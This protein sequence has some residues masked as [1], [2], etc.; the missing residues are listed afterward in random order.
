MFEGCDTTAWPGNV[1][2]LS[3]FVCLLSTITK[4]ENFM[5]SNIQLRLV[6][7]PF[8]LLCT[9]SSNKQS[10]REGN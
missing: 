6:A 3:C 10:T 9:L 7:Q 8:C 1:T 4:T 5:A 2:L